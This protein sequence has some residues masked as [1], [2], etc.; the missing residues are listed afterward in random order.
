MKK[1]IINLVM[2]LIWI[3]YTGAQEKVINNLKYPEGYKV[4]PLG[5]TLVNEYGIGEKA[6]AIIAD[7]GFNEDFFKP[8]I[9][10]LKDY[11]ILVFT[12]P[13]TPELNGYPVNTTSFGNRV[14]LKAIQTNI[15]EKL[16]ESGYESY[17]LMGHLAISTHLVLRIALDQPELVSRGLIL[18][19]S[20]YSSWPSRSD[21]SGNTPVKLEERAGS[22]DYY[23][24]PRFYKTLSKENWDQGLYQPEHYSKDEDL[25]NTLYTKSTK[26][27]VTVLINLLCEYF[28]TNIS[29]ELNNIKTSFLLLIPEFDKEH[30]EKYPARKNF[31]DNFWKA[32]GE[33]PKMFKVAK[34]KDLRLGMGYEINRDLIHQIR[35][36]LTHK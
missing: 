32:D 22:M 1:N 35:T 18:A 31:F 36:F 23:L 4:S 17:T 9:E 13:G 3:A 26:A 25:G 33:Y 28:T 2:L 15:V 21:P 19:G 24:A 6:I 29:S 27:N 11:K 14:W 30:L 10:E 16:K 34:I 12:I 20:P 5:K 8:L 7:P